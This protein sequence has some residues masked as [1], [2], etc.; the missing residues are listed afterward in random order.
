M[1]PP[2]LEYRTYYLAGCAAL[3]AIYAVASGAFSVAVCVADAVLYA[4]ALYGVSCALWYIFRYAFP[5]SGYFSVL[6]L[7]M[8]S[9][10]TAVLLVSVESAMVWLCFPDFFERF[11]TT[12]PMRLLVN[13]LLFIIARLAYL[14]F[15]RDEPAAPVLA[16]ATQR[17][18]IER[19][20]VRSGQKIKVIPIDEVIY[21]QADGDYININTAEGR[22]LKEQTMKTAEE[23]LPTDRF[24]RVHRSFIVNIS[25]ISRIERYGEQQQLTLR[26][27]SKIRISDAG[28]KTLRR[29]LGL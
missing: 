22:W 20:T 2:F 7:S 9:V 24:V 15:Y 17:E 1:N 28:Y 6:F 27:G 29:Q 13:V 10:L 5:Q 21:I 25:Q 14:V 19:F 12:V 26:N 23:Q 8:L 16:A 4:V 11:I 3:A 18:F